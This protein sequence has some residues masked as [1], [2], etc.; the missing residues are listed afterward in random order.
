MGVRGR[1]CPQIPARRAGRAETW[2][3]DFPQAERA[4]TIELPIKDPRVKE[5]ETA[6]ASRKKPLAPKSRISEI[7]QRYHRRK[8]NP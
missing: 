5:L 3:G 8:Y 4:S 1:E 7:C 6:R 2:R